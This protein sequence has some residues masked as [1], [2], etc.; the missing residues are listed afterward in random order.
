MVTAYGLEVI[1]ALLGIVFWS[2]ILKVEE[3][4][5]PKIQPRTFQHQTFQP[6]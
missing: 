3:H 2:I 6:F 1:L 4:L 5:N